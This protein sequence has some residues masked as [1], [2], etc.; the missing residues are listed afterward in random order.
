MQFDQ[1]GLCSFLLNPQKVIRLADDP[2]RITEPTDPRLP[3]LFPQAIAKRPRRKSRSDPWVAAG[4]AARSGEA[5]G[6]ARDRVWERGNAILAVADDL[7]GRRYVSGDD[8]EAIIAASDARVRVRRAVRPDH[9]CRIVEQPK[10]VNT[11][12]VTIDLVPGGNAERRRTIGSFRIAN[13][14]D[15]ADVSD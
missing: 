10:K 1:P 4:R 2:S 15:P 5:G 9:C 13:I 14:S 8:V 12:V 7:S 3:L 6:T 11:L